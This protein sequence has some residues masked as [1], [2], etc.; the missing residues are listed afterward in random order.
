MFFS[1]STL[2]DEATSGNG[3]LDFF[4]S[5]VDNI[6]YGTLLYVFAGIMLFV[7]V[8]SAVGLL[9]SYEERAMRNIRKINNYLSKHPTVDDGNIVAFNT[10]MKKLP[11]RIRDRWQ[12]Y[13][14]E[15]DGSPSRYLNIEYC[16]K[17]PLNNSAFLQMRNQMRYISVVL[18]SVSLLLSLVIAVAGW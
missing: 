10:Q 11:R 4:K 17:R 8:A 1:N 6:N 9:W 15:R 13:M 2:A 7:I 12:L 5:I 3:V 16:V 18:A 14:L